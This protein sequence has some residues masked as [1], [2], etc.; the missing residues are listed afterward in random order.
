MCHFYLVGGRRTTATYL[1]LPGVYTDDSHYTDEGSTPRPA[2][3]VQSL[4]RL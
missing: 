2:D 4:Y 3:H 1:D